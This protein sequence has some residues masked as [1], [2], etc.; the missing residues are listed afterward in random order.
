MSWSVLLLVA[1]AIRC[2]AIPLETIVEVPEGHTVQISCE[3]EDGN[4]AFAFWELASRDILGPGNEYDEN[5]YEYNVL[6]GT[7]YVRNISPEDEGTYTC[8]SKDLIRSSSLSARSVRMIVLRDWSRYQDENTVSATGVVLLIGCILILIGG[9][10][11]FYMRWSR[12]HRL[13]NLLM[14]DEEE[15][16]GEEIFTAPGTSKGTG[17]IVLDRTK[18]ID[19]SLSTDF[20]SIL[21]AANK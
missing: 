4:H 16:S 9:G 18:S 11:L 17:Q 6:N 10:Y 19:E 8:F 21:S 3:S 7:L 5:K 12:E 1:I 2:G 14:E 15:D 13:Q 20:G